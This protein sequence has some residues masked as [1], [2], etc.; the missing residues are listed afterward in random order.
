MDEQQASS[1]GSQ[2]RRARK[3]REWTQSDLAREAGVAPGTVVSIENAKKVRPGNLRAVLDAL[4]IPPISDSPHELDDDVKLALEIVQRWLEAMT[5]A[6]RTAAI[7]EL[8]RFTVLGD[9]ERR[10]EKRPDS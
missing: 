7:R 6:A 5:E 9:W 1:L 2:V 3:A 8:T 10:E 4:G